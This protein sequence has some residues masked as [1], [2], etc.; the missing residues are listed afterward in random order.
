MISHKKIKPRE[1]HERKVV[2]VLRR[3]EVDLVCLAGYMRLLSSPFVRAYPGRIMNIHPSLLPAFGGQGF[4]GMRVHRAVI[5][6]GDLAHLAETRSDERRVAGGEGMVPAADQLNRLPVLQVD[7]GV[8]NH[9]AVPSAISSG[10]M[11][12][13]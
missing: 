2:E 4:Y 7:R 8:E 3:Y 6:R 10:L 11:T 9:L 5:E 12:L 13:L 1:A